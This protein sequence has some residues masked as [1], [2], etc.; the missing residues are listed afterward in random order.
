[1]NTEPN[2]KSRLTISISLEQRKLLDLLSQH[3]DRSLSWLINQ[4]ISKYLVEA[5]K[6]SAIHR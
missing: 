6:D 2:R 4:A 1:M 5:S 3:Q